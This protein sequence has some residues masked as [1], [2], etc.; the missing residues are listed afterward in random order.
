[1]RIRW[2]GSWPMPI[3]WIW[4]ARVREMDFLLWSITTRLTGWGRT[5]TLLWLIVRDS[6]A[7]WCLNFLG[8]APR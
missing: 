8:R 6:Q 7:W 5:R 3:R 4:D 1:M 2:P